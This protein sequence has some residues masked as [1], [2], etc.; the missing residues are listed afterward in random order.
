MIPLNFWNMTRGA[1]VSD[2]FHYLSDANFHKANITLHAADFF[3]REK[4][5]EKVYDI[6]FMSGQ[7]MHETWPVPSTVSLCSLLLLLF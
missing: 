2:G 7:P 3:W 1:A 6:L 4:R 5:G